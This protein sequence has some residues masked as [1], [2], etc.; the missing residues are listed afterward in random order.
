MTTDIDQLNAQFAIP[1]RITFKAGAGDLP[2]AEITA[3]DGTRATVSLHGAHVLTYQPPDQAP[4]LWLSE[5][6]RYE[7]GQAIRGG[8]PVIW[9]WFGPHPTDPTLTAWPAPGC[10]RC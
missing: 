2:L 7:A 10:G 1:N 9:P 4:A 8:I 6:S 3:W 5:H